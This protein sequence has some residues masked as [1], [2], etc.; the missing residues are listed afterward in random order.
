MKIIL[1]ANPNKT[2]DI[3]N[4]VLETGSFP[5][6]WK[7]AKVVLIKKSGKITKPK[8]ICLLNST[9]KIQHSYKKHCLDK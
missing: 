6:I 7:R 8:I 2:L 5:E 1:E 9:G 4:E 3:M